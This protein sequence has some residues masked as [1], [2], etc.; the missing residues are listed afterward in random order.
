MASYRAVPVDL[1][2][3]C[4]GAVLKRRG[5][6]FKALGERFGAPGKLRI[7]LGGLRRRW[8]NDSGLIVDELVGEQQRGEQELPCFG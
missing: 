1:Y 4:R 6:R 7:C 5:E 8:R 3:G 2:L